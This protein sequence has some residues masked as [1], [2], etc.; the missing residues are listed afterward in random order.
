M[1]LEQD[2]V[3]PLL[4]PNTT[5]KTSVKPWAQAFNDLGNLTLH[6]STKHAFDNVFG[7]M[8]LDDTNRI[9]QVVAQAPPPSTAEFVKNEADAVRLF[10]KQVSGV[11]MSYFTS[12]PLVMELDQSGP[13]GNTS[14]SGSVDTQ[15]FHSRTKGLLAIGE[16]KTPGV[17][18]PEWSPARQTS[19]TQDLGREL[20]ACFVTTVSECLSFDFERTIG[21][22]SRGATEI[23]SSSQILQAQVASTSATPY[24][25]SW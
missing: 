10:H 2:I 3:A 16:H 12:I 11:V 15:F 5:A 22:T 23:C 4:V 7:P 19:E 6:P 13:L 20:R 24:I 1:F 18:R 14:F 21:R 9:A 8:S 25:A 17:I